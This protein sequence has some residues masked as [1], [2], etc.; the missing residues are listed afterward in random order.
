MLLHESGCRRAWE[1]LDPIFPSYF[2]SSPSVPV[3]SP[4]VT[5]AALDTRHHSWD[6][7]HPHHQSVRP[8]LD[9]VRI[10]Q[11]QCVMLLMYCKDSDKSL[12]LLSVWPWPCLWFWLIKFPASAVSWAIPDS[13]SQPQKMHLHAM[14]R[15][16]NERPALPAADQS[17]A[18]KLTAPI[19]GGTPPTKATTKAKFHHVFVAGEERDCDGSR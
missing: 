16:A 1:M 13:T 6:T 17:E 2:L 5:G 10:W 3:W 18:A 14:K 4:V 8:C 19:P 12:I 7:G 11:W 15:S 9:L